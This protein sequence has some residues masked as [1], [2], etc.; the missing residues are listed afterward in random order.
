MMGLLEEDPWSD[1]AVATHWPAKHLSSQPPSGPWPL[2]ST[3]SLPASADCFVPSISAHRHFL[4]HREWLLLTLALSLSLQLV[5][6]LLF[7]CP[8]QTE[9]PLY[10]SIDVFLN[11]TFLF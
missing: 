10:H 2:A 3:L 9:Q 8:Q 5:Y 4:R 6:Q 7:P 1:Q 11:Q